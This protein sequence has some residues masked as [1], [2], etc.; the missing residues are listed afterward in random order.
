MASC[1]HGSLQALRSR[2]SWAASPAA[3]IALH[4]WPSNQL[5]LAQFLGSGSSSAAAAGDRVDE[6]SAEL[7]L[8][9]FHSAEEGAPLRPSRNR[10]LPT[11]WLDAEL[12]GR[13]LALACDS[14]HDDP[15]AALENLGM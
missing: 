4:R 15:R 12:L 6:L 14:G 9:L 1:V 5:A 10:S 8:A 3:G 11:S 7:V 13:S 2:S